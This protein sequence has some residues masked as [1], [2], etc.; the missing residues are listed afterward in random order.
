MFTGLVETI[1]VISNIS[2]LDE[3]IQLE[4]SAPQISG[5]LKHGDS[6]SVSGACLTVIKNAADRFTVEMMEETARVTKFSGI[7]TGSRVN[8]ERALRFDSR[9]DGHLV[10]GHVDGIAEVLDIEI[11]GRTRKYIFTAGEVLL[12]GM[13]P[14]GS[15]AIDGVSLTL[16]EAGARSFSVGIIP[17]TVSDTTIADLKRGDAVNIETDVIGKYV[18]K[19]LD[20]EFRGK[21]PEQEMKDSLTWDKL[22][23]YGW[24]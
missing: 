19:L 16:I 5:E 11:Y 13:L 3:V 6:V 14:K 23:E 20:P 1:G 18:L 8:L 15:V 10:A 12:R 21:E 7:R 22:A 17:T 4:I 9:L 24:I 2:R